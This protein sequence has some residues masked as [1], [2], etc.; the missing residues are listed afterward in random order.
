MHICFH[1]LGQIILGPK[2]SDEKSGDQTTGGDV[3][4]DRAMAG[5]WEDTTAILPG[6]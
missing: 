4:H 2:R 6:T 1:E 3:I 5:K